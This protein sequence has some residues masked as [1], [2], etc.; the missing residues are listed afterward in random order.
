M[1][2]ERTQKIHHSI[3]AADVSSGERD[4]YVKPRRAK[5]K[6]RKNKAPVSSSPNNTDMDEESGSGTMESHAA[7]RKQARRPEK[8]AKGKKKMAPEPS[9]PDETDAEE[10]PV[11]AAIKSEAVDRNPSRRSG[12][13]AKGKKKIAPL[14]VAT[15]EV[16]KPDDKV[17]P[18]LPVVAKPEVS[19]K[20]PPPVSMGIEQMPVTEAPKY[21]FGDIDYSRQ[22]VNDK[23]PQPLIEYQLDELWKDQ[24]KRHDLDKP[25][26]YG[27][28]PSQ[29]GP[30]SVAMPS[31][32]KYN[33]HIREAQLISNWTID[34]LFPCLETRSLPNGKPFSVLCI[35]LSNHGPVRPKTTAYS[36]HRVPWLRRAFWRTYLLIIEWVC[37]MYRLNKVFPLADFFLDRSGTNKND[38]MMEREAQMYLAMVTKEAKYFHGYKEQSVQPARVQKSVQRQAPSSAYP[39]TLGALMKPQVAG[40]PSA[41]SHK[42]EDELVES[43]QNMTPSPKLAVMMEQARNFLLLRIEHDYKPDYKASVK[44]LVNGMSHV[45]PYVNQSSRDKTDMM[46][47][48]KRK[49]QDFV[50]TEQDIQKKLDDSE[51]GGSDAEAGTTADDGF[52]VVSLDLGSRKK[53]SD[54]D[55]HSVD[56]KDKDEAKDKKKENGKGKG[57][58]EVEAEAEPSAK[59]NRFEPLGQVS[60]DLPTS[61]SEAEHP[62][63]APA[64]PGAKWDSDSF[65]EPGW[66]DDALRKAK[67]LAKI[68]RASH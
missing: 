17:Y 31:D 20:A 45:R 55:K 10:E 39:T 4:S 60:N 37:N 41:P 64:Q 21:L 33:E 63:L 28:K 38:N 58:A 47:E 59:K 14:A 29:L 3:P 35:K 51:A 12:R 56:T 13:G 32:V 65:C 30:W 53:G 7:P 11:H 36:L 24:L 19:G 27:L 8:V 68:R 5:H 9:S 52:K 49:L 43:W 1:D 22:K 44:K 2:S 34:G 62:T 16:S 18:Q 42:T 15:A 48:S 26:L 66:E 25:G 6:G 46:V 61:E 40:Q 67:K 50:R 54:P 57:K 23:E